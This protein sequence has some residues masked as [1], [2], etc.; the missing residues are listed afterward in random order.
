MTNGIDDYFAP[1]QGIIDRL[2]S[3]IPEV[4]DR[5]F[6]MAELENSKESQQITPA[7]HVIHVGDN[8][9]SRTGNG[10]VQMFDQEYFVILAIRNASSVLTGEAARGDAGKILVKMLKALQGFSPAP[11]CDPLKR[12]NAPSPGYNAGYGYFPLAFTTRMTI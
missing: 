7:I 12:T 2:K 8:I 5:V 10:E 3:E 6:S 4:C 9:C 11:G 1:S